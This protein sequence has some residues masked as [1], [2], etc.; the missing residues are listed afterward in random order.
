MKKL[1]GLLLT[2]AIVL[3]AAVI[4]ASAVSAVSKT[5]LQY[6]SLNLSF[7]KAESDTYSCEVKD[8]K[9]YI[10]VDSSNDSEYFWL[11]VM[12]KKATSKT[13]PTI[14]IYKKNSDNTQTEYK[15]YK[16]KVTAAKTVKMA[17]VK[18][19][20]KT[21]KIVTVKN[22]YDKEYKLS[23]NKKIVKISTY[24]YADNKAMYAVKGLKKGATTVK[25]YLKGTKKKIGSFK[26]TVGDFKASVRKVFKKSML[27]YNSHIKSYYLIDGG[28]LNI[29][30]VVKNFH[31]NAKYTVKI[32]N[33]KILKTRKAS[34]TTYTPEAVELY[35]LKTGKT[36]VT[37]YEKRGSAKKKKIGTITV[38]VKK[39]KDSEVYS[40]NRELD[41]DGIFYELFLKVG[42]K[43]DLKN[44][45]VSRYINNKFT[46]SYF[47]PSEYKFTFSATPSNVITVDEN[48]VY[49]CV[50]TGDGLNTAS[51]KITFKDGS[52]VESSG[53][54]NLEK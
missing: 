12:S 2:F 15:K 53:S 26:I 19:N 52:T 46:G 16:I 27:R 21:T 9:G 10:S 42:E 13:L 31:A 43:F 39:A 25:A 45:V 50:S 48:G 33:T 32:K 4:P 20:K 47:K 6:T 5:M 11:N 14:T 22:P 40:A 54:F 51:Y 38:T 41:N 29:G 17:N 36:S 3:G 8:N 24:F 35:A 23:Y 49:T 28:T 37:I 34:K 44:E 7:E 30:E 1:I 18:L